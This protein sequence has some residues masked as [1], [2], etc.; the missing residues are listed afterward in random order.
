MPPVVVTSGGLV[1][2]ATPAG[3]LYGLPNPDIITTFW[4][5]P[6]TATWI[7]TGADDVS[8]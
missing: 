8:C 7:A 2:A 3:T 4:D 5:G 6:G 1:V